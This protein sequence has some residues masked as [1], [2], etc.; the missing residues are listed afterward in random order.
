M[1]YDIDYEIYKYINRLAEAY[2][3]LNDLLS[4]NRLTFEEALQN[5][6]QFKEKF[7]I[8]LSDY[9]IGNRN[10][11]MTCYDLIDRISGNPENADLRY[12]YICIMTDFGVLNNVSFPKRTEEQKIRNYLRQNGLIRELSDFLKTQSDN[13][14]KLCALKEHLKRPINVNN[15]DCTEESDF[16]YRLTIQHTLLHDSIGNNIYIDNLND[17]IM[18]INSDE[19]L[20]SVKPYV[21]FAVLTRK[22]GMMQKRKNFIPNLKAVFQYQDYNIYKDNGKNFNIYQSSV[23]LYDHLQRAYINEKFIDIGLCDFCFANL[24]PLSEWYYLNCEKDFELPMT[25]KRK[26]DLSKPLSFPALFSYEDNNCDVNEFEEKHSGIYE[27]WE[28]NITFEL[29]ENFLTALYYDADKSEIIQKLPYGDV[30][31]EYA[32]LFL[33]HYAKA[34]LRQK[35]LDVSDTL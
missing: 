15:I 8:L 33:Y 32:E 14:R 19:K 26:L 31:P 11:V 4:Q 22:T 24:S 29:I 21:I 20:K 35:M 23:E 25:F 12:L 2:V 18:H 34:T 16:L 3:P 10:L 17:L 9:S 30:Y 13:R 7:D 1:E 28:N 6:K 27:R 5:M